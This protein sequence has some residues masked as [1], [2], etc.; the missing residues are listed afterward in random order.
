MRFALSQKIT[1][2]R[3]CQP[4]HFAGTV[5]ILLDFL[6]FAHLSQYLRNIRNKKYSHKL[7]GKI[8]RGSVFYDT[9]VSMAILGYIFCFF[10]INLNLKLDPTK[11]DFG[12]RKNNFF[13]N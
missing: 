5:P 11:H 2:H 1:T 13:W 3:G 6:T 4:Y 8:K 12:K 10:A 7:N 9:L